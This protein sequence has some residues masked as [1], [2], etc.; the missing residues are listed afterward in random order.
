M[1]T[2]LLNPVSMKIIQ[3]EL[4]TANIHGRVAIRKPLVSGRNA[5]KRLQW[6]RDHL[7]WTQLQWEQ[8]IW[9]DESSFTLFQTTGR[10]F[11]WQALTE[12]FHVDCLVPTVKHGG[13]SVMVWAA[14]S[15]RGLGP[16]VVLRGMITGD[17]YRSILADHLHPMLQTLFP[18]EC[19]VFQ[20]DNAPVHT[21]RCVQTWLH[22]HDDEV[23]HLT[24]CPQSPD[25]NIIE[26][27]WGYLENKVCSVSTS[28]HTI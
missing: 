7:N 8:V 16:L 18:G 15:S 21:S 19:L 24:W 20:D 13:G 6:C 1:N 2:H 22:E 11:V 26:P 28:S 23:E 17:H 14:I 25:L 4:H 27:L 10:V 9:S 5:A 3:R 12:A